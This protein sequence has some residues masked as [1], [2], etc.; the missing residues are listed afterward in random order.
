M[1]TILIAVLFFLQ[2]LTFYFLIILN[3][4]L[5]KFKDLE[6]K[7]ERLMS[8]MDDTISVYLTEMKDE[9]DR[10]IKE[11]Q[12]VS[13]SDIAATRVQQTVSNEPQQE[14]ATSPSEQVLKNDSPLSLDKDARIY[15]P[16]NIVA[17]AYSRQQQTTATAASS[18]TP[19]KVEQQEQV[20]EL[21]IEQQALNLAKQ[22][23][24][25]EE[26]AKQLQKGK[27]EI[28]LLLKFHH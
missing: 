1:T 11:L 26:I 7:Q 10:L 17:N 20:K 4:K 16:K 28:E 14:Q 23:K 22:G 27:T 3:T 6:K 18:P 8:E 21:T 12:N 9:N 15:V 24:S 13:S 19:L 2:L 25:T 5:A